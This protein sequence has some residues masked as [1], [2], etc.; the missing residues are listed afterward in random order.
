MARAMGIVVLVMGLAFLAASA[1]AAKSNPAARALTGLDR[2]FLVTAD[3]ANWFEITGGVM[4]HERSPSVQGRFIGQ[5]IADRHRVIEKSLRQTAER[6]RFSLPNHL[7]A[8]DHWA[9]HAAATL[10]G[11]TFDQ[12]YAQLE[13]A[14]DSAAIVAVKEELRY[15]GNT[16]ARAYARSLLPALEANLKLANGLAKSGQ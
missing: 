9:L 11:T 3:E 8:P 14:H 13:I 10:Y 7:S 6:L 12:Q 16:S 1:A 2:Q 15:G 4:A 5:Q